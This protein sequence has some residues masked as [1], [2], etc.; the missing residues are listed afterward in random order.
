MTPPLAIP[1]HLR[2]VLEKYRFMDHPVG[3]KARDTVEASFD[4]RYFI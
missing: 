1:I 3:N 2:Q 4:F